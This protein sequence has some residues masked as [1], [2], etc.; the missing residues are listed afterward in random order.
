MS[1]IGVI[2]LIGI[3]QVALGLLITLLNVVRFGCSDCT[4]TPFVQVTSEPTPQGT[5]Q[6]SLYTVM[7]GTS[8][9]HCEVY[10]D[11]NVI[12]D[13]NDWMKRG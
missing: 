3:L 12:S 8:L 7:D 4:I 10:A 2:T 1:V 13:I 9:A 5:W 6:V 11:S